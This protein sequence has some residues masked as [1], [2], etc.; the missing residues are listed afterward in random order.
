MKAKLGAE[1]PDTIAT[2]NNLALCFQAAGRVDLALPL[3]EE[4]LRLHKARLGADHPHTLT[5]LNNLAA[6]YKA[7]GKPAQAL[8]LF[9]EAFRLQKARL[10][11]DH[12]DTLLTMNN[13]AVCH[14]SLRQL[15]QAVPLFEQLL[16]LREQKLGR[17][18]PSTQS[19]VA[20]LGVS[21]K[22]TGR[23]AEALP[24]LEEAY[25]ASARIPALRG[26]AGPLLDAYGKAGKAAEAARLVAALLADA[27]RTLPPASPQL[28]GA[29][30]Q[31]GSTLLDVG[32]Y[33]EA[34][35]LLRECLA[36]RAQTQPDAWTTFNTMAL[37]G[38]ALLGRRQYAAAEPLLLKGYA[39]LK[40]R[41]QALP[42][43]AKA[44]LP[45]AVGRLVDLY[46]AT[47]RPAEAAKWRALL[48]DRGLT[49]TLA[50]PLLWGWPRP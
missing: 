49:R 27:R 34:E 45:E 18:H 43:Q 47:G 17:G 40:A 23:L 20:N 33:A 22:D 42:P 37:L 16:P 19:T 10:G 15:D 4:T 7:T 11:A 2:Q 24:L 36:L 32:A 21:Y 44:R 38:G 6:G 14:W 48:P 3:F 12:P 31:Y 30:A 5:A 13:L 9:E 41:E 29:L 25:R 46:E 28:A 35:P 50:W 1:H 26:V 39:G 8:P